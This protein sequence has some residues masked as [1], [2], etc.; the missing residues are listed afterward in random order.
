MGPLAITSH[1]AIQGRMATVRK[2]GHGLTMMGSPVTGIPKGAE[3]LQVQG[4]S[5]AAL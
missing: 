5:D 4:C 3:D 1:T 2:P